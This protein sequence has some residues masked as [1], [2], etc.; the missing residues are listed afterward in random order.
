MG[1]NILSRGAMLSVSSRQG[2]LVEQPAKAVCG[3]K[4]SF[5]LFAKREQFSYQ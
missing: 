2:V 3:P 4:L 1:A 5:S